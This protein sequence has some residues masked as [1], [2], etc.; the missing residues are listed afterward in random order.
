[1]VIC[2]WVNFPEEEV[3]STEGMLVGVDILSLKFRVSF[4]LSVSETGVQPI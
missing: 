3:S 1:M 4:G 2:S